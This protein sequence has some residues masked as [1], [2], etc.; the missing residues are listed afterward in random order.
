MSTLIV[1]ILGVV[2]L[3]GLILAFNGSIKV[4]KS[5]TKPFY[6]TTQ[7]SSIKQACSL[8]CENTDKLTFCCRKYKIDEL[9]IGCSDSRLDV[10]CPS[11]TCDG[12]C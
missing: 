9:E 5:S 12:V 3:I 1:I 4:F 2:V 11:M 8:A 7:S 6:D 10:D